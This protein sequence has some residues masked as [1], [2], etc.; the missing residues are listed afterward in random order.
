[1]CNAL[2]NE[3][4]RDS[5]TC[6]MP[7]TFMIMMTLSF[8]SAFDNQDWDRQDL[9]NTGELTA[10]VPHKPQDSP[11]FLLLRLPG[12]VWVPPRHCPASLDVL[13]AWSNVTLGVGLDL[14]ECTVK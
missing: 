14:H 5:V 2:N 12:R 6:A 13:I 11:E 9:R 10:F 8:G 1:M 7:S 4:H 3:D